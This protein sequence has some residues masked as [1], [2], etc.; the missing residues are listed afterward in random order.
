[1]DRGVCQGGLS[2]APQFGRRGGGI[3]NEVFPLA[4]A[5]IASDAL[6]AKLVEQ[7]WWLNPRGYGSHL[8]SNVASPIFSFIAGGLVPA[9]DIPEQRI[10]PFRTYREAMAS[11][12]ESLPSSYVLRH[13]SG[14]F[15]GYA[16]IVDAGGFL[17]GRLGVGDAKRSA[18]ERIISIH[19]RGTDFSPGTLMPGQ[20]NT[21]IP[22][23]WSTAT[24]G[25]IAQGLEGPIAFRICADSNLQGSEALRW[26]SGSLSAM[27]EVRYER[28]SAWE[29]LHALVASDFIVPSISSFS[30]LAIFLSNAR[31]VWPASHLNRVGP[32]GSIWHHEPR[33]S[34]MFTPAAIEW[35]QLRDDLS[36]YRSYACG[37][38]DLKRVS[39]WAA[40]ADSRAHYDERGDLIMYGVTPL[41][42]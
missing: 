18:S 39:E 34:A 29:D 30:M 11:I 27:G 12:G 19:L 22:L 37:L 31:Y 14:M 20:F 2:V 4:K 13:T 3:G 36:D 24:A 17:A 7:P 28:Q 35:A 42:R 6:G 40:G 10:A 16:G 23:E 26:I 5:Y 15:G 8:G 9:F 33:V 41:L 1:M 25:A 38:E 21:R 32:Y